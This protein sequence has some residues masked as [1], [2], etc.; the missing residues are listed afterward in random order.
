MEQGVQH[1]GGDNRCHHGDAHDHDEVGE[2]D[3]KGRHRR[4]SFRCARIACVHHGG[5]RTRGQAPEDANEGRAMLCADQL[6]RGVA[7]EAHPRDQ[8]DHPPDLV[9]VERS[10][11][12]EL[13]VGQNGKDDERQHA[14]LQD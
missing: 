3:D 11:G 6:Q 9:R 14:E 10:V 4:Q 12:A 7:R 8:H 5:G 1:A 2:H 13:L